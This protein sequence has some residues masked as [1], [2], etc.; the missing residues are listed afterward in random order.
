MQTTIYGDEN[1]VNINYDF[2]INVRKNFYNIKKGN[3]EY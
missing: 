2:F 1:I 3:S